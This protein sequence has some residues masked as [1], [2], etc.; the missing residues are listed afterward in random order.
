MRNSSRRIIVSGLAA[1]VLA[2]LFVASAGGRTPD[3][4]GLTILYSGFQSGTNA[5]VTVGPS[6]LDPLSVLK[7]RVRLNPK[8]TVNFKGRI[9][10]GGGAKTLNF[11][12]SAPLV[13]SLPITGSKPRRCTLS[14]KAKV[15]RNDGGTISLDV[16]G[17]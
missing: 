6:K 5:Y 2:S 3:K 12:G 8:D 1:I 14:G 13:R 9:N 4:A 17:R 7:I 10:C 15:G 11:T 16:L